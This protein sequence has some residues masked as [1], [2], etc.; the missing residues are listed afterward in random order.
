MAV[1]HKQRTM[2]ENWPNPILCTYVGVSSHTLKAS[3][4]DTSRCAWRKYDYALICETLIYYSASSWSG[5]G[6]PFH[7]L[8]RCYHCC[9]YITV[10]WQI[11]GTLIKAISGSCVL[12]S[13]HSAPPPPFPKPHCNKTGRNDR[14]KDINITCTIWSV[15]HWRLMGSAPPGLWKGVWYIEEGCSPAMDAYH[16]Q[17]QQLSTKKGCIST[18]LEKH[19]HSHDKSSNELCSA[20][21]MNQCYPTQAYHK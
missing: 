16:C 18:S 21:W 3:S 9:N 12:A 1:P 17:N 2:M 19:L 11:S 5:F 13:S 6:R 8:K 15:H 7:T 4:F 10:Q 14:M 20:R